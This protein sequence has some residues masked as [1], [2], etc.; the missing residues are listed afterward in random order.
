MWRRWAR[1]AGGG[2]SVSTGSDAIGDCFGSYAKY[3]QFTHDDQRLGLVVAIE[4]YSGFAKL[5]QEELWK[6]L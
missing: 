5:V 1:E 2:I 4:D 3:W 6:G